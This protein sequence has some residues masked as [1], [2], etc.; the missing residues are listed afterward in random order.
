MRT[1]LY[2]GA[3]ELGIELSPM[4]LDQFGAFYKLLLLIIHKPPAGNGQALFCSV[5]IIREDEDVCL[6]ALIDSASDH[7]PS[8]D[9]MLPVVLV[10]LLRERKIESCHFQSYPLCKDSLPTPIFQVF[11][12]INDYF[13]FSMFGR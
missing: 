4:Q 10:F 1:N 12:V 6:S 13:C 8:K 9:F 7:E 3:K 11:G 5:P 2:K